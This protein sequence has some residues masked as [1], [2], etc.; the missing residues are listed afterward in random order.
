MRLKVS[1]L[2]PLSI[3]LGLAAV[4]S[5]RTWLDRQMNERARMLEAQNRVKPQAFSTIVVA[6]EPLR[7][8]SELTPGL[9][10][11]IP[12]PADQ[13]PQGAF[14]KVADI[15]KEKVKR[16][17]LS[18]ILINEPIL[19]AKITGP[20]QKA[21]LAAIIEEGK[22]A[23]TVRV[24]DVVG[25]A[26]FVLPGDRVDVLLT[27][28]A[29]NAGA[30]SDRILQN[31][32]VLAIDQKADDKLDKPSIAR[33]VTLEVAT[34]QAQKLI[35]AQ[36]VGTLTLILRPV[37]EEKVEMSRRITS[38]QLADQDHAKSPAAAA[39]SASAYPS[40]AGVGV[41]R[42][43]ARAEYRVPVDRRAPAN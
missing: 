33:A 21:N 19:S 40:N 35:V 25:V 3:V 43:V 14:Q 15:Q 34:E 23:V 36:N 39:P 1:L 20:G 10:K 4:Q 12:W 31:L 7:Y 26:G 11:E 24:D 18:S 9:L 28:K 17:A 13:L 41:F 27:R 38:S 5:G 22:K 6:K 29:G 37:G 16:Y 42:G 2:I 30:V 8:G 32:K